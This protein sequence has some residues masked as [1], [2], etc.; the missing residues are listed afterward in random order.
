MA[1]SLPIQFNQNTDNLGTHTFKQLQ[2][3]G[4]VVIYERSK[5]DGSLFGFEVF[6]VKSHTFPGSDGQRTEA[7]EAY[8]RANAFGK[9]AWFCTTLDRA[10]ARFDGLL[11]KQLD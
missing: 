7:S 9:T 6:I 3:K 1:K 11:A 5:I 4:N 8:P 10:M 2:R